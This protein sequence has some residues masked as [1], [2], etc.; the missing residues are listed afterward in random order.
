MVA[1]YAFFCYDL[2][3]PDR[4]VEQQPQAPVQDTGS[5]NSPGA[6]EQTA[7]YINVPTNHHQQTQ[8]ALTGTGVTVEKAAALSTQTDN[9]ITAGQFEVK[10]NEKVSQSPQAKEPDLR[11]DSRGFGL[12]QFIKKNME[13]RVFQRRN[14]EVTI[15]NGMAQP[16]TVVSQPEPITKSQPTEKEELQRAA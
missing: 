8:E 11:K 14:K 9:L 3:M 7:P 13:K 6:H 1:Q 4:V 12:Y 16:E 5:F 2:S 10:R 15:E